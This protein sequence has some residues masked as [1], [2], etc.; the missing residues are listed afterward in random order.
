M[1]IK[2]RHSQRQQHL[3]KSRVDMT[4]S[5]CEESGG[6]EGIEENQVQRQEAQGEQG[7]SVFSLKINLFAFYL[8]IKLMHLMYSY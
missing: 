3:G 1:Y 6:G 2:E 5:P 7:G 4:L 8:K